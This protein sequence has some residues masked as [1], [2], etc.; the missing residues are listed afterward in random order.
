MISINDISRITEKKNKIK[1]ETY[2][3]I[4][5]QISRKLKQSVDVGGKYVYAEIPA[6]VLGCPNYDRYKATAYIKRQFELGGFIVTVPNDFQLLITWRIKK[7]KERK[8][9][10]ENTDEDFPTLVNLKKFANKYRGYAGNT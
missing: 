6:F 9:K 2:M 4:Y 1:K 8:K 3:R 10:E 5:E 7:E